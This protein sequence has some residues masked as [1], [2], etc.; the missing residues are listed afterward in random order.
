MHIGRGLQKYDTK[1]APQIY[2]S[3]Y[4][5]SGLKPLRF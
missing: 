2:I 3:Q 1:S 5:P 4:S